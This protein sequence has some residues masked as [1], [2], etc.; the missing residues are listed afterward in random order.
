MKRFF[1]FIALIVFSLVS[2]S[3]DSD[4]DTDSGH[5]G[6][7]FLVS[8]YLRGNFYNNGNISSTS[9]NAC[10]DIICIGATPNADGS[11]SFET[12]ELHNGEGVTTYPELVAS[13]KSKLADNI[14]IR[15]GISGGANWKKMVSSETA[16]NNF[17]RNVNNIIETLDLDGVDL[18]F[19]WANTQEEYDNYSN[20]IILLAK[21]LDDDDIF[22]VTL[23]PISYKI[24][25]KAIDAVTYISL[26]CYGPSPIRFSYDNYISSIQKLISY[27]VPNRKIVPGL[28]FYGVT[29]DDSK[30]TVT[31]FTLVNN[32]LINSSSINEVT[33]NTESYVF[34]GQDLIKKKVNYAISQSFYGVMS[35]SLGTDVDYTNEWSLLRSINSCLTK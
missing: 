31:Y 23:D 21:T 18:D 9:L 25:N 6:K 1:L 15:L 16:I 22:S 14:S 17:A 27:G 8:S 19:E 3:N 20:A 13:V 32:G 35:W 34:N 7:N 2:C 24:S 10:T 12:F 30:A 26:Q 5:G 29:A 11:L 33:Y 28:P 4:N